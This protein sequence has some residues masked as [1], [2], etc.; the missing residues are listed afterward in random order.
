MS[1]AP[2]D[3]TDPTRD[4]L[5]PGSTRDDSRAGVGPERVTALVLCGGASRRMGRDKAAIEVRGRTL[6]ARTADMLAGLASRV[7]LATGLTQRYPELGLDCVLDADADVGPLAGL[8]AGL[9]AATTDW[10]A[11]APCDLPSADARVWELLLE[12]AVAEDLDVVRFR[13]QRGLE[14][15]VAVLHRRSLGALLRA[16][17]A[18]ERKLLSFDA[19]AAAADDA[20]GLRVGSIDHVELTERW[21]ELSRSDP[22]YNVNT[23]ADLQRVLTNGMRPSS[24]SSSHPLAPVPGGSPS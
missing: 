24:G 6:V 22:T 4:P 20:V 14:P 19:Y 10:V 21:P 7:L 17:A 2:Q 5:G 8:A 13:S 1:T 16:L 11:V 15:A 12:R 23:P 3:R 9:A 18:G